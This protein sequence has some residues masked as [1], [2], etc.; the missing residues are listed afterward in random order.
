M[1]DSK[2]ELRF[3]E[4]NSADDSAGKTWG[5]EGNLFWYLVGGAL[6]AVDREIDQAAAQL[7]T[8]DIENR[9]DS[10]RQTEARREERRAQMKEG[11]RHSR[12]PFQLDTSAPAFPRR[13]QI[14]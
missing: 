2:H 10:E 13:R 5:L 7:A 4:T 3:T 8:Q 9:A 11:F 12:E 6:Q 1:S 14:P